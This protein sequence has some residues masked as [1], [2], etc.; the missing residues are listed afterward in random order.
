V[1]EVEPPVAVVPALL[2]P[3]GELS[4]EEEHPIAPPKLKQHTENA[5][6]LRIEHS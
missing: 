4:A 1:S 5:K 3:V 2:V 6:I